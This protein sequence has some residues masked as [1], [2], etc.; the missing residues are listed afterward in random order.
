VG[1]CCTYL[2]KTL[3]R[4]LFFYPEK[5]AA[6]TNRSCFIKRKILKLEEY[7]EAKMGK[8]EVKKRFSEMRD[9]E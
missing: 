2:G 7:F 9:S 8:A 3:S 4:F 1:Q 5:Q 6:L